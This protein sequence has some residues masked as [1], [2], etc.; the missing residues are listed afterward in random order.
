MMLCQS[1][2]HIL[3]TVMDTFLGERESQRNGLVLEG[4]LKPSPGAWMLRP[5]LRYFHQVRSSLRLE[6]HQL[7]GALEPSENLHSLSLCQFSDLTLDS[8][9]QP[10]EGDD[11]SYLQTGTSVQTG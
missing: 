4:A 10:W 5:L 6:H 8:T 7:P 2:A 9:Q 3:K 1:R 11:F